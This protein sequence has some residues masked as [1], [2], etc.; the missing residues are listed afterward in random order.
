MPDP[1]QMPEQVMLPPQEMHVPHDMT[2]DLMG[3]RVPAE[4]LSSPA[5]WAFLIVAAVVVLGV[6]YFKYHKG[7]DSLL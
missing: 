4:M 7:N 3:I 1:S 2:I 6:V 5:F